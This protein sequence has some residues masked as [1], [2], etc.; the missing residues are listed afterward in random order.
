MLL[1]GGSI[2]STATATESLSTFS[3]TGVAIEVKTIHYVLGLFL[4]VYT[5]ST[6]IYSSIIVLCI[7]YM[8]YNYSKGLLAQGPFI[9]NYAVA[10]R[11]S[12]LEWCEY[13]IVV[14]TYVDS[15]SGCVDAQYH[16]LHC[17]VPSAY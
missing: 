14:L 1:V 2:P 6:Y 17:T 15:I 12:L 13:I 16:S 3:K 9:Y 11:K 4:S 8:E 7:L 10:V 5:S